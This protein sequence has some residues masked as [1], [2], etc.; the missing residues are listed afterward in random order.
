L[1][2]NLGAARYRRTTTYLKIKGRAGQQYR[3]N[4]VIQMKIYISFL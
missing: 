3:I 1:N 2:N 4:H